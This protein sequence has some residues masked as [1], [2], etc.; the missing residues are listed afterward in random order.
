MDAFNNTVEMERAALS[1]QSYKFNF[2]TSAICL[3]FVVFNIIVMVTNKKLREQYKI[4]VALCWTNLILLLGVLLEAV[5]RKAIYATVMRG[6]VKAPVSSRECIKVWTVLQVYSDFAMPLII[7]SMSVERF[8]AIKFPVVYLKS[9]DSLP[10]VSVTS[11]L[12]A[13]C[14]IMIMPTIISVVWPTPNVTFKCGRKAAFGTEFGVFDYAFSVITIWTALVLTV[15]TCIAAMS[16]NQS[17]SN[18]YKMKCYTAI[19]IVSTLLISIPNL[20]SIIDTMVK[21]PLVLSIPSSGLSCVNCAL[22]FFIN[23]SLNNAFRTHFLRIL[24]FGKYR[25]LNVSTVQVI[26]TQAHQ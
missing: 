7:L 6:V 15:I 23:F 22:Q 24:S 8:I 4:L 20:L 5:E 11:S 26:V 18:K 14:A 3:L 25:K 17:K 16:V 1:H 12:I 9:S 10:V 19:A 2:Y 13:A 21:L